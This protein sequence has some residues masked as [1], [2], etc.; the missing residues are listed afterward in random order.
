MKKFEKKMLKDLYE[1]VKGLFAFTFY[2]RYSI[3][4]ED[5]FLFIEKYE[6]KGVLKYENDR[7]SL[8]EEGRSIILRQLFYKNEKKGKF[9]NIPSEFM[10]EKIEINSLYLPDIFNIS[11]EILKTKKVE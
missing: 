9:S 4:P 10:H 8:T 3:E 11:D 5:M 1:S 2:S 6:R 7:L